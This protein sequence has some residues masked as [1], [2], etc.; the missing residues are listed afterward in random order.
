MHPIRTY[1]YETVDFKRKTETLKKVSL[2]KEKYLTIG[3]F[4]SRIVK[5]IVK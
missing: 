1:A 4:F 2:V 5:V 3:D